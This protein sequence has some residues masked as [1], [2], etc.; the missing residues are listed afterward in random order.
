MA[1]TTQAS[2]KEAQQLGRQL[3][4][5]LE[6][7]ASL[8]YKDRAV[9]G[10]LDKFLERWASQALQT[11]PH[12]MVRSNLQRL[13]V[14]SPLYSTK[15]LVEREGWIKD[16]IRVAS[17][18]DPEGETAAPSQKKSPNVPADFGKTTSLKAPPARRPRAS[19]Q[20]PFLGTGQGLSTPLAQIASIDTRTKNRLAK[21]G[22]ETI[23]DL[24]YYFPRRHID[25]TNSQPIRDLEPGSDQTVTG[26]LFEARE[27]RMGRRMKAC[28]AVVGDETGTVRA[29]WFNQPY[30]AKT[31]RGQEAIALSGRVTIFRGRKVFEN[32]EWELLGGGDQVHTG[33]LIPIYPL[34]EGITSRRLRVLTRR[35]IDATVKE[36]VDF[37]PPDLRQRL[38]LKPLE[39]AVADAHFPRDHTSKESSRKRLAFDELLLIQ[40]GVLERKRSWKQELPGHPLTTDGELIERFLSSLDFSLTSAQ[41]KSLD[42]VITDLARSEPMTRLLQGDVGSGKTVVAL[43]ALLIAA[44]NGQQSAFMAPTEILAEQHFRTIQ[45]IFGKVV[46][47]FGEFTTPG[48]SPEILPA[49]LDYMSHPVTFALLTGST[50]R[51]RK[52]EI[53]ELL[54]A[55]KIDVLVGTHA[56]IQKEVGFASLG[57]VI[58]DEQHRFGVMQRA[59]LRQKGYNPHLLVMTATPIPRSL[60]L[61]V[62]GDLDVST[63]DEMPAGRLPIQTKWVEG[64]RREVAYEFVR[65]EAAKGRQAFIIYPLIEES[66]KLEAAAAEQEY[67]RLAHDVFPELSLGLLHGRLS[68]TEKDRAMR[69]F[70]DGSLDILVSTA[71]VEVGIDVP[72]A[73]T[74]IV[75]SADRFGLSQLH[76]FR[77][78]VGRGEHQSYCVL[79]SE[80]VNEDGRERLR[81][82]EETNDGFALAEEDL[83]LRG[84]GEFFG[85]KQSGIPDLRMARLSDIAMIELAREEARAITDNDPLLAAHEHTALR[86]AVRAWWRGREAAHGEA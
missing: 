13:G 20:R 41:R 38:K 48:Q 27:I 47:M 74:M 8:G 65:R 36:L 26:S 54:A 60:S 79:I 55:G 78:R 64:G 51:K 62:F 30:L 25:F 39:E 24:L 29:V 59:E 71:V 57:L 58:V 50:T 69:Q 4:K 28:E 40:I 16:A 56:L 84:P 31:L 81:I 53:L 44:A 23:R 61:T 33:G 83:R 70:R 66:E 77:G 14:A 42:H 45:N 73:T 1:E 6:L 86:E 7:E 37:Q 68:S 49:E 63:I 15:S 10:G 17:L 21:L 75:D 67:A 2:S 80:T 11:L 22:L 5:V 12:P 35:S 34:T 9:V 76:Q 18:L 85:T 32:P 46:G 52:Q 19:A 43:A 3:R 72:N 82:M